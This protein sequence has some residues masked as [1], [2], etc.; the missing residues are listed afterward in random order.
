MRFKIE[1]F[2]YSADRGVQIFRLSGLHEELH[3][4]LK[5]VILQN[6][7][8]NFRNF[9]ILLKVYFIIIVV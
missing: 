5:S 8:V 6:H 9:S 2:V 1:Y 3:H 7:T 4:V